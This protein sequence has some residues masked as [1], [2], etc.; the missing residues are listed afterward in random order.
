MAMA[1]GTLPDDSGM[2]LGTRCGHRSSVAL[3]VVALMLFPLMGR[4]FLPPFN[5]GALNVNI[6]LPPGTSLQESNRI[7][8]IV[9]ETLHRT[10]KSFQR[11]DRTGARNWTNM[12]QAST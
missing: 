11:R 6:T 8:R 9:E 2:A 12:Q 7:G 4:E 1:E 10:P 3:L 5:E